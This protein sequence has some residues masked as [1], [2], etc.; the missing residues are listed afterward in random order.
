MAT[1]AGVGR[2]NEK[3]SFKAG[4]EATQSALDEMGYPRPDFIFV[5]S[6]ETFDQQRMI[7]GVKSIAGDVPLAGCC[8]AGVITKEGLFTDS[9]AVITLKSDDLRI[10][11]ALVKDI[12]RDPREAGRKVGREVLDKKLEETG[13]PPTLFMFPDGFTCNVS[14]LV[15]GAYDILGPGY[16]LA[17]GGSGDNLKFIKT[18]QF[19]EDDINSDALAAA[20]VV[21]DVPTGIG[22]G[23]GYCPISRPLI[24]TKAENKEI[25]EIDGRPA[26]EVYLEYFG[27]GTPK[28]TAENFS[29]FGMKYPLGL[30]D[31]TGE[32]VIRDPLKTEEGSITCVAEVPENSVVRIMRGDN[33]SV[34]QAAEAAAKRALG[35]LEG[36]K[37]AAALIFDCVSRLLLLGEDSQ[38]EL[39]TIRKVIG[40][41]VPLAGFLTFGEIATSGGGPPA[42]HNKNVVIWVLAE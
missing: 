11:T 35:K 32:Y 31:I 29:Q 9:T 33:E 3:D 40:K 12:S 30:P 17:G 16:Q 25:K 38:R 14:E 42:F 10:T 2:S 15:N 28:L 20:L 6:T 24:I 36:R 34:I 26:F 1:L 18:Y 5:F 8:S 37:P 41:N 22:A 39:D 27:E 19:V 4:C 23:H 21:S 13:Y 7:E